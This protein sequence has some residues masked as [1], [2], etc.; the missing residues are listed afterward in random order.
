MYFTKD[1]AINLYNHYDP[2]NRGEM[3]IAEFLV[4]INDMILNMSVRLSITELA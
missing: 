1:D 3:K 4:D 2:M